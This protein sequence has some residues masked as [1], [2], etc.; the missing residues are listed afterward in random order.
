MEP[1]QQPRSEEGGPLP[2]ERRSLVER[3]QR[4]SV[5]SADSAGGDARALLA[6]PISGR[7]SDNE[8]QN[9]RPGG[10][11]E[12]GPGLSSSVGNS[13][14]GRANARC[15]AGGGDAPAPPLDRSLSS[16]GER[17]SPR[18]GMKRPSSLLPG[19]GGGGREPAHDHDDGDCLRPPQT[20]SFTLFDDG[21]GSDCCDSEGEED[22]LGSR[23]RLPNIFREGLVVGQAREAPMP[24]VA[25][26]VDDAVNTTRR[27][28]TASKTATLLEGQREDSEAAELDGRTHTQHPHQQRRQQQQAEETATV[29]A[30]EKSLA[31]IR[32]DTSAEQS[33]QTAD[34]HDARLALHGGGQ[35]ASGSLFQ[36]TP[37]EERQVEK[38]QGEGE[39]RNGRPDEGESLDSAGA[40]SAFLCCLT[41]DAFQ[42]RRNRR[43]CLLGIAALFVFFVLVLPLLLCVV[44][45][46]LVKTAVANTQF[47]VE[48]A[49]VRRNGERR[50]DV[51]LS[52][53]LSKP[54]PV[55][56]QVGFDVASPRFCCFS[57]GT[58][59][60][61]ASLGLCDEN[62][63]Y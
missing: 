47:K 22:G 62:D 30:S 57:N 12:G 13:G 55:A 61:S 20:A 36:R 45:P 25:A 63:A 53:F 46:N 6:S 33:T 15:C 37:K 17:R 50:L 32:D 39:G 31:E 51:D 3:K 49:D 26:G 11:G 60:I 4:S 43:L 7:S 28:A 44:A 23:R 29:S 14:G 2:W 27:E 35:E 48:R 59:G 34:S 38:S 8:F 19:K 24:A 41:C 21:V 18:E 1:Q 42:K 16:T 40:S 54:P 56:S 10:E 9:S 58:S 52:L 5:D